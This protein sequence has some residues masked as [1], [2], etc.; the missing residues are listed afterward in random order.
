[1]A[2]WNASVDDPGRCMPNTMK[3]LEEN[4]EGDELEM[5]RSQIIHGLT[6]GRDE[7]FKISKRYLLKPSLLLLLLTH[8]TRGAPFLRA[9]L[10]VLH[11]FTSRVPDNVTLINDVGD[12]WGQY[13]YPDKRDRPA[14]EREYYALLTQSDDNVNDLL[15]F[16]R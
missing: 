14:D 8:R 11:E 13:I 10:S 15:H 5:R 2:W 4:F 9:V 1:M 7:M 12:G 6:M 16:W 3:Y